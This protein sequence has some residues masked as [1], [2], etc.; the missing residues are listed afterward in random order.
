MPHRANAYP[1][2]ARRDCCDGRQTNDAEEQRPCR[3]PIEPVHMVSHLTEGP[4]SS[5][6]ISIRRKRPRLI[7]CI[8]MRYCETR[9]AATARP[10]AAPTASSIPSSRRRRSSAAPLFRARQPAD[11]PGRHWSPPAAP[12]GSAAVQ[13][14]TVNRPLW[15]PRRSSRR[16]MAFTVE[17]RPGAHDGDQ[18]G[19]AS[20]PGG[21][22]KWLIRANSLTELPPLDGVAR[23]RFVE[24]KLRADILPYAINEPN[25]IMLSTP[26]IL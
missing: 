10:A 20:G 24:R 7:R 25:E 2:S 8:C 26:E 16:S 18:S 1:R 4:S 21:D 17:V 13:F 23:L 12:I 15:C 11:N 3:V 14:H 22:R 5:K 9:A 19:I 6:V